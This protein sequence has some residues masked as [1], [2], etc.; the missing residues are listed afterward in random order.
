MGLHAVSALHIFFCEF[1]VA[2]NVGRF[3]QNTKRWLDHLA[4][5]SKI[6][7]PGSWHSFPQP[8]DRVSF[9]FQNNPRGEVNCAALD[10]GHLSTVIIKPVG[11]IFEISTRIAMESQTRSSNY[12]KQAL[13]ELQDWRVQGNPV[14]TLRQPFNPLPTFS[15]DPSLSP[16]FCGPQAQV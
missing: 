10:P 13:R 14:P 16:S 4:Q 15:D 12:S 3:T 11:W 5:I 7:S 9:L 6:L 8:Q 2:M 1:S